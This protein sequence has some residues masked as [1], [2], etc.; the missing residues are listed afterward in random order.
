MDDQDRVDAGRSRAPAFN[1]PSSV[2]AAALLLIGVHLVLNLLPW[3]QRLSLLLTLA[4]IPARY[5]ATGADLPGGDIADLTSFATYMLVHGSLAHLL[6]NGLWMLAFGSA[7]AKRLGGA[8]FFA[9]S[10]FCGVAAAVAHLAVHFGEAVPWSGLRVLFRGTWQVRFASC[11]A[12][13]APPSG[14]PP[15]PL[16]CRW[17][18]FARPSPIAGS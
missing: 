11:L 9:F 12:G 17:P 7:V 16:T 15:I 14:A 4:F 6:V 2:I 13:L 18:R 3:E 1:V 5:T 10:I 8:R